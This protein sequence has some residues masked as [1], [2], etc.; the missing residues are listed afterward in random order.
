MQLDL[1]FV[2][3]NVL[4]R[5]LQYHSSP[6]YLMTQLLQR[7]YDVMRGDRTVESALLAYS[8]IED[9]LES[10]QTIRLALRC[11]AVALFAF[12][13]HPACFLDRS[14]VPGSRLNSQ[15]LRKEVVPAIS[16]SDAHDL[17]TLPQ[18]VDI[19]SK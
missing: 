14:F 10:V 6:L 1:N 19:L 12:G 8:A 7:L 3:A 11:D 13:E 4:D 18:V 16:C 2:F 15:T 9:E 17:P 5:L